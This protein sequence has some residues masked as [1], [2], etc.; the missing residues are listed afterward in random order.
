MSAAA[1]LLQTARAAGLSLTVSGENLIV[2][3]DRD[4][5]PE[6]IAK[7][8]AHKGELLACSASPADRALGRGLRRAARHAAADRDLI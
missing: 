6:L 3:A 5:P 7:L 2:E 4:P 1:S 8:R